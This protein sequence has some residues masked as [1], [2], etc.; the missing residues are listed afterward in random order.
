MKPQ[1]LDTLLRIRR[2]SLDDAERVV[3]D[4]LRRQQQMQAQCE[5]E[6]A[7]Y[8]GETLAA[9]DLASG[10]E[11]VDAFA[12]W[13]PIGR[14]T[15]AAAR[16]AEQEATSEVDRARILLGLSRAA[17]RSVELLIEKRNDEARQTQDRRLQHAMDDLAGRRTRP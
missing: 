4:A 13:L 2:A 16:A 9:L 1:A 8:A 6:E 15:V 11:A 14:Q 5:E 10:D 12:R 7:R 17:H 3:A